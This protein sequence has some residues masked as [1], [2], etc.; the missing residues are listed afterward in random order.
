MPHREGWRHGH[1]INPL[2]F[3]LEASLFHQQG[4]FGILL[5]DLLKCFG[6]VRNNQWVNR[7]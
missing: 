2:G 4:R 3:E 5:G 1:A 7:R 6:H